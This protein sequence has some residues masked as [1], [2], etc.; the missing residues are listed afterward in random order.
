MRWKKRCIWALALLMVLTL[1]G[2]CGDPPKPS[3][4]YL[5]LDNALKED[6]T[7]LDSV[8]DEVSWWITV[9]NSDSADS[10]GAQIFDFRMEK[11]TDETVHWEHRNDLLA[12][13]YYNKNE[14]GVGDTVRANIANDTFSVTACMILAR[15][16]EWKDCID[17]LISKGVFWPLIAYDYEDADMVLAEAAEESED[18]GYRMSA[19]RYHDLVAGPGKEMADTIA[20]EILETYVENSGSWDDT[21][22]LSSG[23]QLAY[24]AIG[25]EDGVVTSYLQPGTYDERWFIRLWS[26]AKLRSMA[27]VDS[28]EV[29]IGLL[30]DLAENSQ[31]E[32]IRE[33]ASYYYARATDQAF[34]FQITDWSPGWHYHVDEMIGYI[35]N[36]GT[37]GGIYYDP[38]FD[39]AEDMCRGLVSEPL[40]HHTYSFIGKAMQKAGA[41]WC[42]CWLHP[43]TEDSSLWWSNYF[44]Q[45]CVPSQPPYGQGQSICQYVGYGGLP[46]QLFLTDETG[47]FWID[48]STYPATYRGSQ[49]WTTAD[50]D[51]TLRRGWLILW[52]YDT[53]NG[54]WHEEDYMYAAFFVWSD[55][56]EGQPQGSTYVTGIVDPTGDWDF[57]PHHVSLNYLYSYRPVLVGPNMTRVILKPVSVLSMPQIPGGIMRP[58]KEEGR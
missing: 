7:R 14:S 19:A 20:E 8:D 29:A 44:Q 47:P 49:R 57:T 11:F 43:G 25:S 40:V 13:L 39:A 30:A 31:Y 48:E 18:P 42:D 9:M 37:Y 34:R 1:K 53:P 55:Q 22:S 36:G 41:G 58:K 32:Y 21:L 10:L 3:E 26:M 24:E 38:D 15:W 6:T 35:Q 27:L 17:T 23:V 16:G 5:A 45:A 12:G 56:P 33:E 54:G 52:N 46:N 28:N 50:P 51:D 2:M 4:G